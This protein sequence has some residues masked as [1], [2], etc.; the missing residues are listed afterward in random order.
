MT[1]G[2]GMMVGVRI[3][4]GAGMTVGAGRTMKGREDGD[5][6]LLARRIVDIIQRAPGGKKLR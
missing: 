1:V 2:A 6:A 4:V 3:T 5:Q